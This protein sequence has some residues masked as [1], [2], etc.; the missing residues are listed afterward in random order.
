MKMQL[1]T[2]K[3]PAILIIVYLCS[4]FHVKPAFAQDSLTYELA[5]IAIKQTGRERRIGDELPS[6]PPSSF[7]NYKSR[8]A[9]LNEFTGKP[10]ILVFWHQY[11]AM[12]RKE[13][14][15]IEQLQHKFKGKVNFVLVTFESQA[16]V[17]SF[18]NDMQSLGKPI[19]VPAIVEDTIIRQ[20]LPHSGDPHVVWCSPSAKIAAITDGMA[21]NETH[22]AL[23]LSGGLLNLPE[24]RLRENIDFSKPL[25]LQTDK[26]PAVTISGM[27]DTLYPGDLMFHHTPD[28]EKA[29]IVNA[30]IDQLYKQ[31]MLYADSAGTGFLDPDW[32]NKR[33][34]TA[35]SDSSKQSYLQ[36]LYDGSYDELQFFLHNHLYSYERIDTPGLSKPEMAKKMLHDLYMQFKIKAS[37][38]NIRVK[39][40]YLVKTGNTGKLISSG[41]E[42][43]YKRDFQDSVIVIKNRNISSLVNV[44]NLNYNFPLVV[45]KSFLTDKIDI[46]LP[47]NENNLDMVTKRLEEFGLSLIPGTQ[48]FPMLVLKKE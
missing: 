32:R 9:S 8:S 16:L 33:I 20:S 15:N 48:I 28:Y 37:I 5:Y 4:I 41:I 31:A 13:L 39:C 46:T 25:L 29:L 24:K 1:N 43:E 45:D 14:Q 10:L 26:I 19:T 35:Y 3:Q 23:W 44:L 40:L 27:I 47:K 18:F 22:I 12:C 2:V 21:V 30:T 11:C 42:P 7:L 36:Q 17:R 6:F 34:I 38:E